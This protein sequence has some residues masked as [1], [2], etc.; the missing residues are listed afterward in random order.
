MKRKQI[1][2]IDAHAACY[3]CSVSLSL[4][5]TQNKNTQTKRQTLFNKILG[6]RKQITQDVRP[7]I[8]AAK[9]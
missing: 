2:K 9:A 1:L 6:Y 3:I 7:T 4:P 8:V 5:H